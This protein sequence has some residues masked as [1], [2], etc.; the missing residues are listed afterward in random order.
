MYVA[1]ECAHVNVHIRMATTWRKQNVLCAHPPLRIAL[2]RRG[3]K[4]ATQRFS[5]WQH[6]L[7]Y[8]DTFM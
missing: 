8:I 7:I 3:K 4:T 6:T 1:V 5:T 2:Q